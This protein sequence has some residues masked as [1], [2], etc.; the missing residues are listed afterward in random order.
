[1]ERAGLS[2]LEQRLFNSIPI[3]LLSVVFKLGERYGV[4]MG[5]LR[6]ALGENMRVLLNIESTV[7]RYDKLNPLV[8][9][10][11]LRRRRYLVRR[12]LVLDMFKLEEGVYEKEGEDVEAENM[13]I[14]L[15]K[16]YGIQRSMGIVP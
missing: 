3:E 15:I 5:Q 13:G 6:D 9:Q 7:N 16:L 2:S 1:M 14:S 4:T 10:D 12:V 8:S 11:V